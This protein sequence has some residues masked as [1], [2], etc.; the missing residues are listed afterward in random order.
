MSV[1]DSLENGVITLYNRIRSKVN[2]DFDMLLDESDI[3]AILKDKQHDYEKSIVSIVQEQAQL[4]VDDL[5]GKL[6]ERMIDLRSGKTV[7]VGGGSILLRKQIENSGK[8][9]SA[10]YVDEI[11]ANTK[12]YELLYYM[13]KNKGAA[14]SSIF[15]QEMMNMADK[16]ERYR[17]TIQFNSADPSHEQVVNLLNSQGRRKAQFLVNAVLHYIHCSETPDI[18]QPAPLDTAVIETV[19]RKI[20]MEQNCE[21]PKAVVAPAQK[22]QKESEKIHFDEAADMLGADG[23][24]AITN[25]MAMFRRE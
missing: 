17:F 24:A 16:K 23:L 20:L 25:T 2:A 9:G 3:D 6:R 8:I 14:V 4:F 1:C 19:V 5:F 10:I 15:C 18:P 7:F 13:A 22:S 12:G 11:S 21:K